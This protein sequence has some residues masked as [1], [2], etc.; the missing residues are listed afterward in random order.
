MKANPENFQSIILGNTGSYMLQIGDTT[1]K[2]VWSVTLLGNTI[3]PKLT[4]IEHIDNIL[5]EPSTL[6]RPKFLT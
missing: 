6:K 1:T 4:F 2:S 5:Y 3:N